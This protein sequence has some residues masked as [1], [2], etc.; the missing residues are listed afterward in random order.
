MGLDKNKIKKGKLGFFFVS[1][2]MIM[3]IIFMLNIFD[4]FVESVEIDAVVSHTYETESHHVGKTHTNGG[5]KMNIEWIDLNGEVQTEGSLYNRD[6]LEEGDT[7]P[8]LVDAETQSRRVLTK[9]GSIVCFILGILFFLGGFG[10]MRCAYWK[11]EC[12]DY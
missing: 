3:G 6:Y 7:F 12:E 8:I 10:I 1:L 2:F 5:P 11:E 9:G 4:L